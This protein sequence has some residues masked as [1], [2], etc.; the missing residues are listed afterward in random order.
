MLVFSYLLF[1]LD[2]PVARESGNPFAIQ[3]GGRTVRLGVI[4]GVA[5]VGIADLR[6]EAVE[7]GQPS[8]LTSCSTLSRCVPLT[9]TLTAAGLAS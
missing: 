6:A 4:N 8:W 7:A 2:K 3:N 5:V 9:K 1:V